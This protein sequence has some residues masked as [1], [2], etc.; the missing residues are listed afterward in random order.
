MNLRHSPRLA[1]ARRARGF[2]LIEL[3]I[4]LMLGVLVAAAAIGMFISNSRTYATTESLSR[5][6]ENAR[7]A[8]E[9]M[10]RDIRDSGGNPCS[11]NIPVAN[12]LGASGGGTGWWNIWGNGVRG[13]ESGA[14]AGSLAGTDAL[15]LMAG[16]SEGA[17]VV[18]HAPGSDR[19]DVVPA[20]H[21]YQAND[22]LLVCDFRQASVFQ[23]AGPVVTGQVNYATGG[24]PG[25]CT[26]QLG[27]VQPIDCSGSGIDYTYRDNAMV[28]RLQAA[29]WYVAANG[30][31][32]NSLFRQALRGNALALPEEV[33][34]GVENMD[35]TYMLPGA[36]AYVPATGVLPA[37]WRE[38]SAVRLDLTL[39][40]SENVGTDGSRINRRLQHT[41]TLRNRNA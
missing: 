15:E 2:S 34:E 39:S 23:M 32:G 20:V 12:V 17:M 10:A 11:R 1:P 14:L 33:I 25:N 6:Q 9:L 21:G 29:R 41:V 40:G 27:F 18:N 31:G 35:I 16:A 30:R 3:M 4:A 28:V 8:F 26:T 38:V 5:V 37:R 36:A 13:Y 24:T 7:M 22:I 19:F